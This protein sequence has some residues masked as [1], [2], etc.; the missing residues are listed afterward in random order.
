MSGLMVAFR[1]GSY[2]GP[3][4]RPDPGRDTE[5]IPNPDHEI[6]KFL[7]AFIWHRTI[8]KYSIS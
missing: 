4:F 6:S 7:I 2:F 3:E 8:F 1:S 5:R